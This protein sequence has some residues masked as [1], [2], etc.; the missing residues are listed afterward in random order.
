MEHR[1]PGGHLGQVGAL[2]FAP[3]GRTLASGDE[4]GDIRLWDTDSG[5]SLR[6]ELSANSGTINRIVFAP[7]GHTLASAAFDGN[8]RLWETDLVR[9]T[10]DLCRHAGS[11]LTQDEWHVYLPGISYR[12]PC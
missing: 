5:P 12:P 2:A 9:A 10:R 6:T 1:R 4:E 11:P 8:A 3:D 7:D